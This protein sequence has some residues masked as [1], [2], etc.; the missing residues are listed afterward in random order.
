[1]SART[2]GLGRG[3]GELFQRTDVPA[4]APDAGRGDEARAEESRVGDLA[5]ATMPDGSYYA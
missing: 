1:M 4:A 2:G 5:S 3:L